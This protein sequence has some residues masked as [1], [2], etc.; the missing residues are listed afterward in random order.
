[1]A[2]VQIIIGGIGASSWH[3]TGNEAVLLQFGEEKQF[4]TAEW[5]IP[6][7]VEP[8]PADVLSEIRVQ[9]GVLSVSIGGAEGFESGPYEANLIRSFYPR[10][11]LCSII[12]YGANATKLEGVSLEIKAGKLVVENL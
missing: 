11:K 7:Y 2:V 1:M 8:I 9:S 12:R 10:G 3:D 5:I 6:S 4:E